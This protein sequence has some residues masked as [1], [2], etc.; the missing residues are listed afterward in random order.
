MPNIGH[1]SL[2]GARPDS[3]NRNLGMQFGFLEGR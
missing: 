1:V 2:C 3:Q